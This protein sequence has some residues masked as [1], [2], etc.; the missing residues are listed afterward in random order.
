MQKLLVVSQSV[1]EYFV[2]LVYKEAE[3]EEEEEQPELD[4]DGEPPPP[5]KEKLK[6][7]EG[8]VICEYVCI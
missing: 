6:G 3:V 2:L 1:G 4:E 7:H 5:P 8:Q